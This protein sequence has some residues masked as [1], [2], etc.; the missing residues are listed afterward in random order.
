MPAPW[1]A[2]SGWRTSTGLL[3]PASAHLPT[4]RMTCWPISVWSILVSGFSRRPSN[5]EPLLRMNLEGESAR[6]LEGKMLDRSG[7]ARDSYSCGDEWSH[8]TIEPRLS[9][10]WGAGN[11]D[12]ART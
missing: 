5:T 12:G 10:G 3:K 2:T 4:S 11:P 8:G 1:R 7:I 6:R 9:G